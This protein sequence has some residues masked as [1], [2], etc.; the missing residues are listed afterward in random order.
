M[1]Y[2]H[3]KTNLFSITREYTLTFEDKDENEIEVGV[4][5]NYQTNPDFEEITNIEF[6]TENVS[7]KTKEVIEEWINNNDWKE[8]NE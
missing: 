4:E 8:E 7:E 6:L 3:K 2:Q 1:I 5:T